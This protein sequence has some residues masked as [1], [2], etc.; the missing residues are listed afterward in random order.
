MDLKKV[1]TEALARELLARAEQCDRLLGKLNGLFDEVT[2]PAAPT[3][4]TAAVEPSPTKRRRGG[5]VKNVE[6]LTELIAAGRPLTV[7]ELAKKGGWTP[8]VVHAHLRRAY[9][10]KQVDQIGVTKPYA[11]RPTEA[12]LQGARST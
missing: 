10:L 1:S 12:T 3:K 6:V 9:G 4:R 5:R 11:Y 2:T 8:A 7:N